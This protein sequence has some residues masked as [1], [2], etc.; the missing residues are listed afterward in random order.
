MPKRKAEQEAIE[1][2]DEMPVEI[3]E[4]EKCKKAVRLINGRRKLSKKDAAK[5][6]GISVSKLKR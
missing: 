6:V 4:E 5:K 2:D 1:E 3:S